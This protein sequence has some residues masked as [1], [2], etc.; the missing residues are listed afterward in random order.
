MLRFKRQRL[1]V[2]PA[3]PAPMIVMGRLGIEGVGGVLMGGMGM[4]CGSWGKM[5]FVTAERCCSWIAW[6]DMPDLRET[7]WDMGMVLS[8]VAL[9]RDGWCANLV[10]GKVTS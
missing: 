6:S 2:R 10:S 1:R 3:R 8:Y 5:A 4:G 7:I 9:G